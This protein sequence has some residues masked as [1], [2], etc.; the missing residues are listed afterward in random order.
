[1]VPQ[2]FCIPGMT[3]YR[4][5]FDVLGIPYLGNPARGDGRRRR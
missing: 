4:A 1:M 5:L 2:M 3:A